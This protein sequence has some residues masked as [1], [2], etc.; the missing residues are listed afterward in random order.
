MIP[1]WM[2]T[3]M[4]LI[5]QCGPHRII[6]STPGPVDSLGMVILEIQASGVPALVPNIGGPQEIILDGETGH[7]NFFPALPSSPPGMGGGA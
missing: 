2:W 3:P 6:V 1:I 5:Y 4:A 7:G